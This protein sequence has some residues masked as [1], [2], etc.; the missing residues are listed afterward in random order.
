MGRNTRHKES[1]CMHF[2]QTVFVYQKKYKET[3]R[4]DFKHLGPTPQSKDNLRFLNQALLNKCRF[5]TVN[6]ELELLRHPLNVAETIHHA[7]ACI[8]KVIRFHYTNSFAGENPSPSERAVP[9]SPRPPLET[10]RSIVGCCPCW[11]TFVHSSVLVL[12]DR[13]LIDLAKLFKDG[14]QVLLLQVPGD[15]AN[16]ELDGIGLLHWNGLA[17]PAAA[18]QWRRGG[19]PVEGLPSAGSV[20]EG[21]KQKQCERGVGGAKPPHRIETKLEKM[22]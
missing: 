4:N 22:L 11:I 14:F 6:G 3:T 8:Y 15:L 5:S 20:E 19:S 7:C 16:E 17:A 10:V 18:G 9:P 13:Q 1:D 21:V 2:S 12:D